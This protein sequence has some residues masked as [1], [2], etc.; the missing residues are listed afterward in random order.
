MAG[1]KMSPRQ[2]MINMMYLV[3]TALLALN[4]SKE[5]L[6][7]FFEVN[8]GIVKTTE[9]I[10]KKNL[11]TYR[12]FDLA[13]NQE[14]VKNYKDLANQVK[15]VS[16]I[17]VEF[18]QEMK[19][20]LVLKVD[21]KVFLGE[22]KDNEGEEI[23]DNMFVSEYSALSSL[24]K[25][26]KIA[27]LGAKDDRNSSG[28]VF[29][30]D[31]K[32]KLPNIDGIGKSTQ[33]KNKIESFRQT[34]ISVLEVAED[35]SWISNGSA[36]FLKREINS[37]LEI[38]EGNSYG[39]KN[40]KVSWEHYNFYDMPSVG[41]LTLLSKWQADIKNME[42]EVISFLA[43]NIDANSL[44]FS[45]VI[46]SAIP[47]SNFVLKGDEFT[48][49][50]TLTAYDKN[51]DAK[52]FICDYDSL[53]DGTFVPK[54]TSEEIDVVNGKGVYKVKTNRVGPKTY[55]GFIKILQDDGDAYYGF[56]NNYVVA[57][58]SFTVS[59]TSQNIL[60]VGCENPITV[61]VGGYPSSDVSV[62][63]PFTMKSRS[64]KEGTYFAK[65]SRAQ[66]DKKVKIKVSAKGVNGKKQSMGFQEFVVRD[67]PQ[68]IPTF[69]GDKV[70]EVSV[71]QLLNQDRIFW[72]MPKWFKFPGIKRT[73]QSFD[74]YVSDGS[75]TTPL[76]GIS[77]MNEARKLL[78]KL[79][80]GNTVQIKNIKTKVKG[81]KGST[82]LAVGVSFS[83][84][85]K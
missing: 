48:S 40:K 15:P 36:D 5:V 44:K 84:T 30:P 28:D 20:N 13:S 38:R 45:D 60:Y 33:L 37:S 56:E 58:K 73:T 55:K 72:T 52:I 27:H 11:D 70:S 16:S 51:A 71:A 2:K 34:L 22:Y 7:S 23:V 39:E 1:G 21:K 53:P 31:N 78:K 32:K 74:L 18:I 49:T 64:K 65:P 3:L 63:A 68:A 54:G 6:N 29:N 43:K 66:V 46:A 25:S 50:I 67:I 82:D 76:K 19:Y 14:K 83:Y 9:S 12:G 59:A 79:K 41:A 77:S 61:A 10:D 80:S 35:S 57:S 26:K 81:Q 24:E 85:I 62:S 8:L 42:A 47:S 4:V 69:L 17:L 75:K